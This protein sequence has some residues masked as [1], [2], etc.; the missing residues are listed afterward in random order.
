MKQRNT[1]AEVGKRKDVARGAIGEVEKG[2]GI[3]WI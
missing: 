3:D 2:I 1:D